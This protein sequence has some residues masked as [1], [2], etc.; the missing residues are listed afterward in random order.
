MRDRTIRNYELGICLALAA[1]VVAAASVWLAGQLSLSPLV[2]AGACTAA[3]GLVGL[4]LPHGAESEAP[5]R[6]VE[7]N[8]GGALAHP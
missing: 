4:A 5:E 6:P 2:V 7:Q 3:F 1:S 8:P